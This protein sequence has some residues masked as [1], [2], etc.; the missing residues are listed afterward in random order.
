VLGLD[1]RWWSVKA[2]V[3][4]VAIVASLGGVSAAGSAIA[5]PAAA[6]ASC[7]DL[8]V[9]GH[10]SADRVIKTLSDV[11]LTGDE[12][13]EI[14]ALVVEWD[15]RGYFRSG[16]TLVPAAQALADKGFATDVA[17]KIVAAIRAATPL[18]HPP[19]WPCAPFANKA[20]VTAWL[21]AKLIANGYRPA[22]TFFNVGPRQIRANA[23]QDG[24]PQSVVAAKTGR[25]TII[26]LLTSVTPRWGRSYTFTLPFDA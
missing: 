2:K 22:M 1:A 7:T 23:I 5:Q 21:R 3:I 9:G 19:G 18:K 20:R 17:A 14:K 13:R 11:P 12:K 10:P 16:T 4:F 6:N 24:D 8:T 25:R 26:V 15:A